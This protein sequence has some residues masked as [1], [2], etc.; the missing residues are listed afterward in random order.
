MDGE[1]WAERW[2]GG[3]DV[4]SGVA[5]RDATRPSSMGSGVGGD[6]ALKGPSGCH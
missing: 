2:G 4:R 3:R 1:G 5:L 6:A